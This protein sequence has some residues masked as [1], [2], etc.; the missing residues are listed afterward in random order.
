MP[1]P[2]FAKKVP[3]GLKA[4][5]GRKKGTTKALML[6]PG[7]PIP[8]QFEENEADETIYGYNI[9]AETIDPEVPLLE[10]Q[11]DETRAQIFQDD[12]QHP[13]NLFVPI[14]PINYEEEMARSFRSSLLEV[15][16]QER[17]TLN[18][19]SSKRS[20]LV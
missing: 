5:R 4:K 9:K 13:E 2:E 15:L 17:V 11:T 20:R 14:T 19:R 10:T 18:T 12:D 8:E 3:L 16:G 7:D 6:Q 1:L